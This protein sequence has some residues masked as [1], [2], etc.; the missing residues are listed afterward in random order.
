MFISKLQLTN[1]KRFSDLTIDL[2]GLETPPSLV[3][4]IGANGSGKSSVFDAINQIGTHTFED[5]QQKYFQKKQSLPFSII[6]NYDDSKWEFT[7]NGELKGE[8]I[9]IIPKDFDL[10]QRFYGRTSYRQIPKLDIQSLRSIPVELFKG[11]FD[12]PHTL[13]DADNKFVND[14]IY[15]TEELIDKIF[16][17]NGVSS[18]E[19]IGQYVAPINESFERIFEYDPS[20]ALKFRAYYPPLQGSKLKLVFSK[21]SVDEL[22]YDLLSA[23]EKEIF[24]IILNLLHRKRYYVDSI[25][26]LDELDL[27]LNTLLQ[28]NLLKEIVENWL[29]ENCQLWTASHSLGFIEYASESKNAAII[30]LDNLD[31]DQQQVLYPVEKTGYDVFEIAVP[32]SSLSA[33]LSDKR[34]V[35]AERTN[36]EL[37]NTLKIPD[38]VFV[39]AID[40]NDVYYRSTNPPYEGLADRDFITDEERM[41]I[42]V[43]NERFFL[44]NYYCFENYLYHPDNYLDYFSLKP[45]QFDINDYRNKILTEKNKNQLIIASKIQSSR[46]T[47]VYFKKEGMEERKKKFNN[48]TSAVVEILGSDD[49]ETFYKVF[50]MKEYCGSIRPKNIRTIDLASTGWF[51]TQIQ[52]ILERK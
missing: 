50:S 17:K 43:D 36:A 24:N 12:H 31:F 11:N 52:N 4:L 41:E 46:A 7:G 13:I 26:F 8:G 21:G 10:A 19:V 25:Y 22:P 38:L 37:Y 39:D 27:H 44:L 49:F 3:L 5:Q 33:L 34:I 18:D 32:S 15:L 20:I 35:F 6:I 9:N 29:P 14:L 28:K 45:G 48:N 42:M 2:S 23:G 40:R 47:Y 16:G 51:K 1:F 30:D